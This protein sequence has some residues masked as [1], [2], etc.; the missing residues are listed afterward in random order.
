LIFNF[1]KYSIQLPIYIFSFLFPR[2]KNIWIFGDRFG[3]RY[4]DNSKFLYEYIIQN[5][6]GIK[7]IWITDKHEIVSR[8]RKEGNLCYKRWSLLGIFYSLRSKV[9][10]VTFSRYDINSLLMGSAI[11]INLHHGTTIKKD[12]Y[13]K[14]LKVRIINFLV[15]NI[16]RFRSTYY[17]YMICSNKNPIFIESFKKNFKILENKFILSG[18]PRNDFFYIN[19][20][21]K[22]GDSSFKKKILYAPTF[23]VL[24]REE[25]V[26]LF[27][28]YSWD[29]AKISNFLHEKNLE[30]FIRPHPHLKIPSKL[31]KEI[32]LFKNIIISDPLKSSPQEELM[33]TD[34][35]IT[36]YSGIYIDFLHLKRPIIMAPFDLDNFDRKE[37]LN[38]NYPEVTPNYKISN[39]IEFI[40][41]NFDDLK[42]DKHHKRIFDYFDVYQDGNNSRRT[43]QKINKL[44]H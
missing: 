7:A 22:K 25:N 20:H 15:K 37:G 27:Y 1:L 35:L 42:F 16:F 4:D 24:E 29:T 8:L 43:F 17:D 9:G 31:F 32:N 14:T 28:K 38:Y 23:R 19:G 6:P 12:F 10:I 36:D 5:E 26:D 11:W 44:F 21:I 33:G 34:F 41:F 2:K 3:K 13:N 39:W 30:L 18:L 40:N